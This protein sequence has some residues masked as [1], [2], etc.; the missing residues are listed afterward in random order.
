MRS[1]LAI[2]VFT[3]AGVLGCSNESPSPG[4]GGSGGSAGGSPL[5]VEP[6][7]YTA[8]GS[9]SLLLHEGDPIELWGAP[10]GGHWS[11]IGARVGGFGTDTAKLVVRAR[12]PD[13]QTV[14][15]E[16]TRTA[17]MVPVEG[18][19]GL[20]QPDPT[21]MYNMA[22]VPLCPADD[23][24][25]IDGAKL[26]L[27]V[28]VIELYGDFSEGTTSLGVVPRCPSE[29]GPARDYCTCE[30]GPDYVP[31]KCASPTSG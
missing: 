12:D 31:G 11:R 26:L 27:E 21:N 23:G 1:A 15:V 4:T 5:T 29:A 7:L 28:Q 13:T 8:E 6:Y 18:A 30:C 10:Q 2:V 14:I 16:A 3:A 25:G 22:H 17:P 19:P 9:G 20:M 24:R